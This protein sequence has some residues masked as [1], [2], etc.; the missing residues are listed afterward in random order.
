MQIPKGLL[1]DLVL[2]DENK[3]KAI[4]RKALV[5]AA[6]PPKQYLKRSL[7]E[8]R[9]QSDHSSGSTLRS[10]ETKVQYPS[11]KLPGY[12]Y[13]FVGVDVAYSEN[14]MDNNVFRTAAVLSRKKSRQSSVRKDRFI[15]LTNKGRMPLPGQRKAIKKQFVKSYQKS[16]LRL[17]RG[18]TTQRNIPARYWHLLE[19]G[20]K[21]RS[22]VRFPGDHFRAKAVAATTQASI[23]KFEQSLSR[24]LK[25]EMGRTSPLQYRGK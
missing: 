8:L 16:P 18:Q 15:A 2:L 14:Q 19:E 5:A 9:T 7:R 13:Y 3:G 22:G 11:K 17:R 23:S 6:G 25:R 12:G 1:D 20:F 4:V 24:G 10:I 21:H